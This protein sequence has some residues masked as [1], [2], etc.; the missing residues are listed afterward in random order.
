MIKILG[1]DAR[2]IV[3]CPFSDTGT[4][5]YAR[6]IDLAQFVNTCTCMSPTY[7]LRFIIAAE[8]IMERNGIPSCK[9][10]LLSDYA[11]KSLFKKRLLLV[12]SYFREAP[13]MDIFRNF[14]FAICHILFYNPF[15]KITNENFIFAPSC[16]RDFTHK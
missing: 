16:S 12:W 2:F 3:K 5:V 8:N 4:V 6:L 9:I 13:T 11:L 14:I 7:T 1:K 10:E 15:I